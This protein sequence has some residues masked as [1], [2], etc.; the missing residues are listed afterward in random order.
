MGD[1]GG[2][3]RELSAGDRSNLYKGDGSAPTQEETVSNI[4]KS[5]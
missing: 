3:G 4:S 5:T 2:S 1:R